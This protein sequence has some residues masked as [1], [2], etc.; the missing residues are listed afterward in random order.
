M[1]NWTMA[2][3]MIKKVASLGGMLIVILSLLLVTGQASVEANQW[4]SHGP[5]GGAVGASAIDPQDGQIVYASSTLG[6]SVFKIHQWWY[7][8][9]GA[10]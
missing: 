9:V 4:T 5:E 3:E 10:Q 8:L 7:N 2:R 1:L 6:G